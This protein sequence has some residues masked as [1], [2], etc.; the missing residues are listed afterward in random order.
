MKISRIILTL[1]IADAT[2]QIT[3]AQRAGADRPPEGPAHKNTVLLDEDIST[4]TATSS[5]SAHV[6]VR[7]EGCNLSLMPP[8]S[9]LR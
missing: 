2:A 1:F 4:A 9:P 6:A 7:G 5:Q 3:E 8:S